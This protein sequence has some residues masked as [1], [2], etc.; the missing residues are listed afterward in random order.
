[1]ST[2]NEEMQELSNLLEEALEKMVED[3]HPSFCKLLNELRLSETDGPVP[4]ELWS[5]PS[6]T[7]R[8]RLGLPDWS[9]S[10]GVGPH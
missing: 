4:L 1:M 9:S 8:G 5:G 6:P 10:G 7:I 2:S 3:Y